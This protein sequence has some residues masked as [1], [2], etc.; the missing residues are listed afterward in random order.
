MKDIGGNFESE[1][2][3]ADSLLWGGNDFESGV[4]VLGDGE[5]AGDGTVL[6]RGDDGKFKV[7]KDTSKGALFVLVDRASF[8]KAGSYGVRVCISGSLNRERLNVDGASLSDADVDALRGWG[9][10]AKK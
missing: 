5:K 4:L 9:I 2:F 3:K 6:T 7:S 8:S 1:D 10:I